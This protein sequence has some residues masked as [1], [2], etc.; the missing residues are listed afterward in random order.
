M[1]GQGVRTNLPR[2]PSAQPPLV[3]VAVTERA[4]HAWPDWELFS[5][6]PC[7][8]V[9]NA[10]KSAT[11]ADTTADATSSEPGQALQH[12]DSSASFRSDRRLYQKRTGPQISTVA[13]FA[14]VMCF[15]VCLVGIFGFTPI[16]LIGFRDVSAAVHVAQTE[17]MA[18]MVASAS[19][20]LSRLP[21]IMKLVLASF[22]TSFQGEVRHRPLNSTEAIFFLS[23]VIL[24]ESYREF[25]SFILGAHTTEGREWLAGV[26]V[27]ADALTAATATGSDTIRLYA[28]DAERHT[29]QE[30]R[31]LVVDFNITVKDYV[32]ERLRSGRCRK[33]P[34]DAKPVAFFPEVLS[35]VQDTVLVPNE[36]WVPWNY[37]DRYA[38][39]TLMVPLRLRSASGDCAAFIEGGL[40]SAHI[41]RIVHDHFRHAIRQHGCYMLVD[42][43]QDLV[44]I[45][46]WNQSLIDPGYPESDYD[47]F[48]VADIADSLMRAGVAALWAHKGQRSVAET[49]LDVEQEAL[50][51]MYKGTQAVLRAS[52]IRAPFGL[53]LVFLSVTIQ[54]DFFTSIDS[55]LSAL[56]YT[57]LLAVVAT[58]IVSY[59]VAVYLRRAI[60]QLTT[61]LRASSKL[62]FHSTT[63]TNSSPYSRIRELEDVQAAYARVQRD[64]MTLKTVLPCSLLVPEDAVVSD[65]DDEVVSRLASAHASDMA[66]SP[67]HNGSEGNE[68]H[69]FGS[70]ADADD[71]GGA[72]AAT[73]ATEANRRSDSLNFSGGVQ[74]DHE[75]SGRVSRQ[76]QQSVV[77]NTKVFNEKVNV[78]HRRYCTMV[79]ISHYYPTSVDE[80]QL[81]TFFK[82]VYA[83]A[84]EFKGCIQSLRPDYVVVTFNAHTPLPMHAKLACDL[85]LAIRKR[86]PPAIAD[87]FTTVVDTNNFLV[88]TCGSETGL[89]SRS[90]FDVMHFYCIDKVL[91]SKGYHQVVVTQSTAKHLEYHVTVP[92]DVVSIPFY[93][94]PFTL[95]ELRDAST[96]DVAAMQ[97]TAEL[98][99][100]G[101]QRMRVGDYVNALRSFTRVSPADVAAQR[102]KLVCMKNIREGNKGHYLHRVR[103]LKLRILSRVVG[104]RNTSNLHLFAVRIWVQS[105]V[106]GFFRPGPFTRPL[107]SEARDSSPNDHEDGAG[108]REE[109]RD[110]RATAANAANAGAGGGE[111]AA[112]SLARLSSQPSPSSDRFMRQWAVDATLEGSRSNAASSEEDGGALIEWVDF[113]SASDTDDVE[114][115][116]E[117]AAGRLASPT[118][119][120]ADMIPLCLVDSNG[121]KW[122]RALKADHAGHASTVYQAMADHGLQVAIKFLPK[123]SRSIPEARLYNE[124]GVMAKLKHLNIV[125]YISYVQTGAHIGI[126]ME[127]APGGSLRGIIDGFG[128]LPESLVRRYMVDILH[129]LAYLH[130]G[131][132]THGDVK[133]HNILLGSDGVCKLSDFGSTV[134]EA[135]DLA[136]SNGMLEFRGTAVYTSPEVASGQLPTAASDIYSLGISFLEMLIGRLPWRWADAK[137]HTRQ[138]DCM[139][140]REVAFVQ[141]VG[142]GAIT[143]VVPRQLSMA[144]REFA[145]ACCRP[146]PADRPTVSELLSFR[147]A[148]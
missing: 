101:F 1:K 8:A 48:R 102:L 41:A 59:V 130:R 81:D 143:P 113:P 15:G 67:Y 6:H 138:D 7:P 63:G 18:S 4:A 88:G 116:G 44:V 73:A 36:V 89:K 83:A 124:I 117:S 11:D 134:C 109:R 136:R 123:K 57:M 133:P 13:L 32:A 108:S 37:S 45:N 94:V 60:Q 19:T 66:S 68:Q 54:R 61:A 87:R 120:A 106:G 33:E 112:A 38:F 105:Q 50:A 43:H 40:R 16:Y 125:Q 93:E 23:N 145:H 137:A 100:S 55:T 20:S 128:A 115:E 70:R 96:G 49:I 126:V 142:R 69:L 58:A 135:A 103:M 147:F 140:M 90:V 28:L 131:G 65:S 3:E 97:R 85:A 21:N 12:A 42:F 79:W 104:L 39:F 9:D 129:G 98:F 121:E 84:M 24:Q 76:W 95:Y 118:A 148:L 64:L 72:A 31:R 111:G 14:C 29:I 82:I 52:S 146:S 139:T 75:Q 86:M 30:P 5:P 27:R 2:S 56:S 77:L 35:D 74:R 91:R 10:G 99:R 53:D 132:I 92:L 119:A 144:A 47:P 26:S 71:T 51:F 78:F 25:V 34:C 22:M 127:Y 17:A 107:Q 46:S 141:S 80:K 62:Q 114:A 122:N 110:R